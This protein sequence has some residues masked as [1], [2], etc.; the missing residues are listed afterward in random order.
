MMSI[1]MN[2]EHFEALE[3]VPGEKRSLLLLADIGLEQRME[4]P[5]LRIDGVEPGPLL[6]VLAAVHGDEY[7]GIETVLRL[8]REVQPETIKGSLLLVPLANR[9]SYEGGARI[10]PEDG[11]NMARVFP[12]R[13]DGTPTERIADLLHRRFIAHADFML[14]LHSG[15][16]HYAVATL[17]GYCHNEETE[18]GRRS[19]A[20]AEAF[21][22]QLLWAHEEV[23]PGRT[24]SSA[25]ELGVPWLYTEAYGGRRI[26][27][28]DADAFFAGS[29]N[30]MQHLHMLRGSAMPAGQASGLAIGH[31]GVNAAGNPLESPIVDELAIGHRH[32]S[33]EAAAH[34]AS[35]RVHLEG[36]KGGAAVRPFVRIYGDGNFDDSAAAS[37][38]GFFIPDVRLG[39]AVAAGAAIGSIVGFDGRTEQLVQASREGIVVMLPG[40]PLVRRGE[41]L[42]LIAPTRPSVT[43]LDR[44]G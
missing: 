30:L 5:V 22:I 27:R 33:G 26:R 1:S 20:A 44:P 10:S 23:A 21:G 39:E 42:Y 43:A 2:M 4:F 40:T 18:L 32:T 24:V 3:T 36:S 7:E 13:A 11:K 17:V 31:L 9:L 15:G 8:Y 14:D 28:E 25:L 16:T 41:P 35:G 29:L 37:A 19:R 12:G 38:D 34:R 6:L